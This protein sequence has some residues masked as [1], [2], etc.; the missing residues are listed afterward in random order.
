MSDILAGKLLCTGGSRS[1]GAVIA[2]RLAA[3]ARAMLKPRLFK[4]L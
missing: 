4:G 3:D 2:K 1:I